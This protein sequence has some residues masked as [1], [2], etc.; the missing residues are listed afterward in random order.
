M[1][2]IHDHFIFIIIDRNARNKIIDTHL[3]VCFFSL[4]CR[5]ERK[6][7]KNKRKHNGNTWA[8]NICFGDIATWQFVLNII[9]LFHTQSAVHT[10]RAHV[11]SFTLRF[12]AFCAN[13]TAEW[14][15]N[16][17][18][19]ARNPDRARPKLHQ[20][21]SRTP[22]YF[23]KLKCN[24][25]PFGTQM[26]RFERCGGCFFPTDTEST[27]AYTRRDPICFSCLSAVSFSFSFRFEYARR[28]EWKWCN[29]KCAWKKP[30][31][32]STTTM[33]FL[34]HFDRAEQI[35]WAT[36]LLLPT[37]HNLIFKK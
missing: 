7:E 19:T 28:K 32:T 18:I 24:I 21:H 27:R 33:I 26:C 23:C 11:G 9:S 30:E 6:R 25:S 35:R 12:I 1:W 3:R 4:C 20:D 5:R 29:H 8:A 10:R 13:R 36:V 31:P 22:R 17:R 15:R 14:N 34:T 37:D 16:I 2:S